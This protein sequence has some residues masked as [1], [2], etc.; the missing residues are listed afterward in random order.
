[1]NGVTGMNE[2]ER[3]SAA[4]R[5]GI[6]GRPVA[7]AGRAS[8]TGPVLH[9]RCA[10][11]EP[12]DPARDAD[13][14]FRIGREGTDPDRIWDY[15]AYGP[16]AE[17]AAVEDWLAGC[18]ASRD[19]VFMVYRDRASG[20]PGGMGSFM[21]L[22]PAVGVGEIG[23]IWFGRAWQRGRHATEVLCLM[24]EHVLE[25]CRYRRLEWKCNALNAP[26]RSAA[27]RLGFRYEGIFLNHMVVKGCSRDTAWFSL[28]EEEWPAVRECH[29]RWLDPG[30]FDADGAQRISLAELTR[31]LW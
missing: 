29:E 11:V 18:A 28:T 22:R 13:A 17:V 4:G 24:M 7:D 20:E 2:N 15:L 31:A 21:E 19:P 6:D 9:G 30:N 27:L 26:S 8:I 14:I 3:A 1:M 10:T 5:R 12:I 16:F 23:N 25:T